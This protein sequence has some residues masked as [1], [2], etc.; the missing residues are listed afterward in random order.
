MLPRRVMIGGSVVGGET[1][2]L[3]AITAAA[4]DDDGS[5][6]P[7]VRVRDLSLY[8]YG[9]RDQ[10]LSDYLI[11]HKMMSLA[12]TI[13]SPLVKRHFGSNNPPRLIPLSVLR[14]I[15]SDV[16]HAHAYVNN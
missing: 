2:G 3:R 14:F 1:A 9:V 15:E 7:L 4:A 16:A 8:G 11:G 12:C 6:T 10:W 13:S 5:V